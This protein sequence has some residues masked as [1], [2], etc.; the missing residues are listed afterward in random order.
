MEGQYLMKRTILNSYYDNV[1][2]IGIDPDLHTT[3]VVL[4]QGEFLL[5]IEICEVSEDLRDRDAAVRMAKLIG[6]S[7]ESIIDRNSTILATPPEKLPCTKVYVGIEGNEIYYK[8]QA[9]PN[10][11]VNIALVTGAALAYNWPSTFKVDSPLPKDWKG[12]TP[13]AISQKKILEEFNIPSTQY[14]D[15]SRPN[16]TWLQGCC[17]DVSLPDWKHVVDAMGLALWASQRRL[18]DSSSTRM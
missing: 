10:D 17:M 18:R 3:P 5:D 11:I 7:I 9:R 2:G 16:T 8:G 15:F 14:K 13:K 1:F 6:Y 12:Q 4:I